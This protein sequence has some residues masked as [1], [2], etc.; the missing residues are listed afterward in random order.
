MA[1][2][3]ADTWATEVGVLSPSAPRLITSGKR[4]VRGTSGGITLLGSLAS[5]GGAAL[6]GLVGAAFTQQGEHSTL[7]LAAALGG[8]AGSFF[9]SLLGASLQ[10][11]YFCPNCQKET[12][13]HP[14][15]T[16]KT[17]TVHMR[18]WRWLGND[19]VNF[20]SSIVGA[21]VTA[22]MWLILV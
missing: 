5:L 8:L 4:V 12:E 7:I 17:G 22:V 20:L 3:N 13:R 10:A 16:C 1:A 21:G 15:H 11:I 14:E 6:V 2:V 19:A 9:D 18:G